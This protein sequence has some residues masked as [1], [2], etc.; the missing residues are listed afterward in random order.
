M[1]STENKIVFYK[2]RDKYGELSNFYPCKMIIDG[3]EYK[4]VEQM[5][6]MSSSAIQEYQMEL[7]EHLKDFIHTR[8]I[9]QQ[10]QLEFKR[11][12]LELEKKK[13]DLRIRLSKGRCIINEI[14]IAIDLAKKMF[15]SVKNEGL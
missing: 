9:V 11:Q 10:E 2:T 13:H 4:T 1:K 7:E 3:I 5:K 14:G 6:T 15:W 12:I 8:E